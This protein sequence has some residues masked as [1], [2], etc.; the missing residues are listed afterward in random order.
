MTNIPKIPIRKQGHPI[1]SPHP[2]VPLHRIKNENLYK[3]ARRSP[4]LHVISISDYSAR[5]QS[6]AFL[7]LCAGSAARA[8]VICDPSFLSL[9]LSA[10]FDNIDTLHARHSSILQT[11]AAILRGFANKLRDLI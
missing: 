10:H 4:H 2:P 3:F 7:S 11:P 1:Y 6:L 9:A 5:R 8:D